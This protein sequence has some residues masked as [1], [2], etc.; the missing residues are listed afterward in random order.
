MLSPLSFPDELISIVLRVCYL[1]SSLLGRAGSRA[2]GI[3]NSPQNVIRTFVRVFSGL[4]WFFFFLP[5]DF[6]P[7]SGVGHP[8]IFHTKRNVKELY[9]NSIVLYRR[10]RKSK[11]VWR[12]WTFPVMGWIVFRHCPP[13]VEALTL[14]TSGCVCV[15]RGDWVTKSLVS[16]IMTGVLIRSSD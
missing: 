9:G 2:G 6:Y 16:S 3:L 10:S 8:G 7:A 14:R 1:S 11:G 4:L 15:W 13:S 12:T 5:V